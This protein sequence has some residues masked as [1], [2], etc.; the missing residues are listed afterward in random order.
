MQ[1]PIWIRSDSSALKQPLSSPSFLLLS[2][3][4][5]LT[6][7]PWTLAWLHSSKWPISSEYD[8]L[9]E[10]AAHGTRVCS[11]EV[12]YIGW[13]AYGVCVQVAVVLI[14][15][16]AEDRH[17]GAPLRGVTAD[18]LDPGHPA[19][20]VELDLEECRSRME[21]DVVRL[22][23]V[24]AI[25]D[26]GV[27]ARSACCVRVLGRRLVVTEVHPEPE[28][29]AVLE[30]ERGAGPVLLGQDRRFG[31]DLDLVVRLVPRAGRVRVEEHR[32][33]VMAG[34]LA[35]VAKGVVRL[36]AERTAFAAEQLGTVPLGRAGVH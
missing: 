23:R 2:P 36:G 5:G 30:V 9:Y 22:R 10:C 15:V 6:H 4:V 33:F 24:G 31:R 14:A 19:R 17:R 11:L 18:G 26:V 25:E 21:A 27:A 29:N 7:F 12:A 16:E 32:R 1:P 8:T 13:N 28:R 3:T 35:A 20:R 34:V